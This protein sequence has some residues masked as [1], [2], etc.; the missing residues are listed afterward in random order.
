MKLTQKKLQK[1][2]DRYYENSDNIR[3]Q[4]IDSGDLKGQAFSILS[5]YMDT[6]KAGIALTLYYNQKQNDYLLSDD[7]Y[8]VGSVLPNGF[9]ND[10]RLKDYLESSV[11]FHHVTFNPKSQAIQVSF[12]DIKKVTQ[13]YHYLIQTIVDFLGAF[14]YSHMQ[15][16]KESIPSITSNYW[17]AL[18]DNLDAHPED[19]DKSL[20]DSIK[21]GR[22]NAINILDNTEKLI[23]MRATIAYVRSLREQV[24]TANEILVSISHNKYVPRKFMV[25]AKEIAKRLDDDVTKYSKRAQI[26]GPT[27]SD[28]N[29]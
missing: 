22:D 10:P 26:D 11:K 21:A 18:T 12:K 16:P 23:K 7:G 24:R 8:S 17:R 9:K 14:S 6:M 28:Q 27:Q 5:P 4:S 20:F 3:V 15:S 2:M 25:N 19:V 13:A 1:I 29:K